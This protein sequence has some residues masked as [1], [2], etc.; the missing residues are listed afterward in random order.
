MGR[1][2]RSEHLR[3]ENWVGSKPESTDWPLVSA[4][5]AGRWRVGV[6]S[7]CWGCGLVCL[8]VLG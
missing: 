3:K 8:G 5:F 7:G 2:D 4:G 6:A 1:G